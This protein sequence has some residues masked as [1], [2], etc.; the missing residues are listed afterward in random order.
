MIGKPTKDVFPSP[1]VSIKQPMSLLDQPSLFPMKQKKM[2]E[3]I[4]PIQA[5]PRGN[6]KVELISIL[7]I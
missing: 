4:N 6:N 5:I 3:S 7:G 2:K 1:A